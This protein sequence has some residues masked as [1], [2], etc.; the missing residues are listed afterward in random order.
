MQVDVEPAV[1][2][3]L[4]KHVVLGEQG[5]RLGRADLRQRVDRRLEVQQ[6]ALL[7]FLVPGFR[8]AV[9]V[10]D[11]R[12][13]LG[14]DL[15][16]QRL[17]RGVELR[18]VAAGGLFE[19]GRTVVERLGDDRVHRHERTGN[20]LVGAHRPELKPIAGE[21]K[22]AGAVAVA[23][24]LRQRRQHVDADVRACPWRATTSHRRP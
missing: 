22:R 6:A 12:L 16:E 3:A 23:G 7:G 4:R 1:D 10:E 11:D 9:A 19:L 18:R 17:D 14:V 24:V 5:L 20:R 8:V 21:G 13:T 2:F 15:R